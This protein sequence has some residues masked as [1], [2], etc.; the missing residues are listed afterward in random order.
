MSWWPILCS[1]AI[2]IAFAM[3]VGKMIA[4]GKR[5]GAAPAEAT[6]PCRTENDDAERVLARDGTDDAADWRPQPSALH[7]LLLPDAL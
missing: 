2:Y 4:W 3:L 5:P 7:N 6:G 1:V